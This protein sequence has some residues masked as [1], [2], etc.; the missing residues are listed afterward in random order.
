[1][2]IDL[3][4]ILFVV[5]VVTD[6]DDVGS[7]LPRYS[8]VADAAR[9]LAAGEKD[10]VQVPDLFRPLHK[11]PVVDDQL[12]QFR[13]EVVTQHFFGLVDKNRSR[14]DVFGEFP[15]QLKSR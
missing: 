9:V 13:R 4:D 10:E 12:H 8:D 1:M 7:L 5:L 3:H 6:S 11:F 15:A 14:A 2:I